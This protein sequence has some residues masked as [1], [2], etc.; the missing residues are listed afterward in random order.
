MCNEI[1]TQTCMFWNTKR[2]K[3]DKLA[4]FWLLQHHLK[5]ALQY[6]FKCMVNY[7]VEPPCNAPTT[8]PSTKFA[9]SQPGMTLDNSSGW[10]LTS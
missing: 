6:P 4:R 10:R 7:L 9:I 8:E 1:R 2:Q 5:C 3:Q